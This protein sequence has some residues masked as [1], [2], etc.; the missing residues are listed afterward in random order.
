MDIS[1]N[2]ELILNKDKIRPHY[3]NRKQNDDSDYLL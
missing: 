3:K 2:Y 1:S